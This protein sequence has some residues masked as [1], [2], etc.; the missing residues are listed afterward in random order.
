MCI[1]LVIFSKERVDVSWI[2]YS[3]GGPHLRYKF[4]MA[5]EVRAAVYAAVGAVRRRQVRL[6]RLDGG[7]RRTALACH[8]A[9][10]SHP[11]T[12][13]CLLATN[14]HPI[15]TSQPPSPIQVYQP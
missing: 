13:E 4:V 11:L 2:V 1:R 6:E 14:T 15:S 7:A 8:P 3:Y 10:V 5:R 12:H 9:T